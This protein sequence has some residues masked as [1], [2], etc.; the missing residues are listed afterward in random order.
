M[1]RSEKAAHT[2]QLHHSTRADKTQLPAP[3]FPFGHFSQEY[4][5]K[6][7]AIILSFHAINCCKN[8]N[9]LLK[10]DNPNF[11]ERG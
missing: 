5:G 9:I 3:A 11:L 4:R 6:V 10:W 2:Q 7:H 8:A 1:G